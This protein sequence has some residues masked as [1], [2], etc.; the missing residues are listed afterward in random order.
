[1]GE[2][3]VD[4]RDAKVYILCRQPGDVPFAWYEY[5]VVFRDGEVI[6]GASTSV[7]DLSIVGDTLMH[8]RRINNAQFQTPPTPGRGKSSERWPVR[9]I[10]LGHYYGETD[11]VDD[12]PLF[13]RYDCGAFITWYEGDAPSGVDPFGE[14]PNHP[15]AKR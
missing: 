6:E 7:H 9:V 10:E 14:C 2:M 5:W 3:L 13:C 15:E 8:S 1:M 4:G 12:D 11:E